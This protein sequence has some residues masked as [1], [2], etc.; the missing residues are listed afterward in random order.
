[1]ENTIMPGGDNPILED[2]NSQKILNAE[3]NITPETENNSPAETVD[4]Q[5]QASENKNNNK[6]I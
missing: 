4:E 1:M 3:E 5:Q 2:E 6:K